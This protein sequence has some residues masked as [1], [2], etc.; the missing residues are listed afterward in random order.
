[1]TV[2]EVITALTV[3]IPEPPGPWAPEDRQRW[4]KAC[5]AILDYF[6]LDAAAPEP[7]NTPD[8][9]PPATER[10]SKDKRVLWL[11]VR[12]AIAD[13]EA[14]NIRDVARG[15]VA[16]GNRRSVK[17]LASQIYG[18]CLIGHA[19]EFRSPARG[20]IQLRSH[21]LAP[22]P[23]TTEAIV[24]RIN[25][26][27]EHNGALWKVVRDMLTE[28]GEPMAVAELARLTGKPPQ[29]IN[30]SCLQEHPEAFCRPQPGMLALPQ[31]QQITDAREQAVAALRG[32]GEKN[33][34]AKETVDQVLASRPD[35]ATDAQA[36]V[37]E[38]FRLAKEAQKAPVAAPAVKPL[39]K[40]NGPCP[41]HWLIG[42]P[43][44][45]TASGT[46]KLCGIS[47]DDFE[48]HVPEPKPGERRLPDGRIGA[49]RA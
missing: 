34:H 7:A 21:D 39:A 27:R 35:L 17:Q 49:R 9:T 45:P 2:H 4:L 6:Y 47:R 10:R 32:L 33:G 3:S 24:A 14:H 19:E 38:A 30:G 37:R 29:Q 36:I 15:L 8:I 1:M 20:K 26:G 40:V 12:D 5:A 16:A 31:W 13:G 44:G 48:N 18:R 43:N 11:A 42:E 23:A 25:D 41:H 22:A 46:C 28:R